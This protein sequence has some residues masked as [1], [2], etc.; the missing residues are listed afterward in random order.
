[1]GSVYGTSPIKRAR[2]TKGDLDRLL[3]G[4]Q[5]ILDAEDD[6]I[7]IRHLFYRL[8]GNGL[9]DKS[10]PA[11]KG[12]CNHL[13]K[14]RKKGAVEYSAFADNSRFYYRQDMHNSI[15]EAIR[16][17]V[18]AYRRNLWAQQDHYV[19]V[20]VEKDAIASILYGAASTYG[21]PVFPCRGF[22]SLSSLYVA[23]EE[24]KRK[25]RRGKAVHVY[26]FGDH[27]PSGRAIDPAIMQSFADMGVAPSF[28]RVAVTKEQ[29]T[30]FNLP[31]RPTKKSDT[32]SKNF[33]GESV[34]IDAMPMHELRRLVESCITRHID[35]GEWERQ[36]GIEEIERL[37]AEKFIAALPEWKTA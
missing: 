5:E 15:E 10:E 20:W 33:E 13:S 31:T 28:T 9:L 17:T 18:D 24:F 37:H 35:T 27:D 21:V 6:Q 11:Y 29:I 30:A 14:W 26:Y 23:A 34:E 36:R 16:S 2:R 12:L 25:A 22:A 32:R 8:V 19:E 1:M 4:V 3:D 7:T